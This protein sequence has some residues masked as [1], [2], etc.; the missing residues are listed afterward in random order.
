VPNVHVYHAGTKRV[1][2]HVVSNGGRVLAVTGLGESI[3][4]AKKAAYEGVQ[5]IQFEGATFRRDIADNAIS[6]S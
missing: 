4:A 6:C 2:N 5:K 1:E 3:K